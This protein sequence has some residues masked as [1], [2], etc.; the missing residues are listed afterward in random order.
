MAVELPGSPLVVYVL[1]SNGVAWSIVD[2]AFG[3][4]PTEMLHRLKRLKAHFAGRPSIYAMHHHVSLPPRKR[5]VLLE[6]S[7]LELFSPAFLAL[8]NAFDVISAI[9][10]RN[11][12]VLFHGHR[13]FGFD[14]QLGPKLQIVS[15]PSTTLG[16]EGQTKKSPDLP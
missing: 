10:S 8:D 3:H 2:N 4:V 13:H 11:P 7:A 5:A 14:G 9:G 15:A 12:T 6:A 1:D 16:D